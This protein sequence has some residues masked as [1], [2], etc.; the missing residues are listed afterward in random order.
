[1]LDK[2]VSFAQ[3][4]TWN[5]AATGCY[6]LLLGTWQY[7]TGHLAATG[8]YWLLCHFSAS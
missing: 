5:L 3:L 7:A 8:C 2:I 6:W 4:E 1:M